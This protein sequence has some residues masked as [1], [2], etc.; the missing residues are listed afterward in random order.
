MPT[1]SQVNLPVELFVQ[2]IWHLRN[3]SD[4]L[5]ALSL[6]CRSFRSEAYRYLFQTIRIGP[7]NLKPAKLDNTH[8]FLLHITDISSTIS[9][10]IKAV[11]L[12]VPRTSASSP[13]FAA[14]ITAA[15]C[16]MPNLRHIRSIEGH[17]QLYS[18]SELSVQAPFK[19]RHLTTSLGVDD[20]FM[21]LVRSQPSLEDIRWHYVSRICLPELHHFSASDVPRLKM[22]EVVCANAAKAFLPQCPVTHLTIMNDRQ[23]GPLIHVPSVRALMI[24]GAI[25]ELDELEIVV[26]QF[27]ALEFLDLPVADTVR[28][29]SRFTYNY[30]NMML[31]QLDHD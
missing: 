31:L 7:E 12:N 21:D 11:H 14:V 1:P 27:P 8:A 3:D 28:R 30:G 24:D 29:I 5:K 6:V 18:L 13:N 4:G 19:L 10:Y 26:R 22:L 2:I 23:L 25:V 15:L 9:R 16:S 20:G 17:N